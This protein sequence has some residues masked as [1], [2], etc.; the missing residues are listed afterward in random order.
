MKTYIVGHKNPDTDSV[1]SAIALAELKKSQ[2]EDCVPAIASKINKETKFVLEKFGFNT[3]ELIPSEEKQVILVDHNEPSQTSDDIKTE[4]IIGIFDHHKLG[5][6]STPNPISVI[7]KPVG[8]TSTIVTQLFREK[9]INLSKN[10]ASILLAG[11]ISD[12]L[13]FTSP[14]STI[15]DK[16]AADF[17]NTVSNLSIDE[18]AHE[19]FK[20][21]SDLTGIS[22]NDIIN[23][24]Y[25]E[26][27]MK[28]SKVGV[29]VFET[30]DPNP[31]L[32]RKEE[33]IKTLSDKKAKEALSYLLFSA[34]DIINQKAYFIITSKEE[35][36]LIE[37]AFGKV[38]KK[39]NY[40]EVSGIVSRKKQII[41]ALE[42][43]L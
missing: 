25:K 10:I 21:K 32:A 34:I 17:L 19:M 28:G 18:L 15:K 31:V 35:E 30:V 11:I 33:I 5:G 16:E 12:T 39:E 24:D 2:G 14:T 37:K 20:E 36:Q 23:A 29:G 3:P 40:L 38:I 7:I 1:V 6:L 42:K 9:N 13:K 22:A 4:E 43:V 8:S 41:P 27:S 26:F